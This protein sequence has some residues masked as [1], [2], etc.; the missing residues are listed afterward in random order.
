MLAKCQDYIVERLLDPITP[1]DNS[2]ITLVV[3]GDKFK[4]TQGALDISLGWKPTILYPRSDNHR[5]E[6]QL[7]ALRAL[8]DD[9]VL[10]VRRL[11]DYDAMS[12]H[13]RNQQ[14]LILLR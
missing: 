11:Q 6:T 13:E 9:M 2:A 1:D 10:A 7:V 4:K 14:F 5:E 8:W 12:N 3:P